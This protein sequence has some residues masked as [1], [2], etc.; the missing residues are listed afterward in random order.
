MKTLIIY[1]SQYGNTTKVAEAVREGVTALA[2]DAK[3]AMQRPSELG[4][5][6]LEGVGLLVVGSPTQRFMVTPAL[7]DW[8]EGLPKDG[9]QGVQVATFDT[10]L[11]EQQI[12]ETPVLKLFVRKSSYGAWWLAKRLQKKGAALILPPEG[13]YVQGT[14][15]PLLPGELERAADWARQVLATAK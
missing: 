7:M 12:K 3:V 8:L 13:F 4:A 1:D 2:G 15:G 10:R 11:T 14:E 9:L 6:S 5:D